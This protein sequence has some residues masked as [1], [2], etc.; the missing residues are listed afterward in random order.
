LRAR[1]YLGEGYLQ[2]GDVAKAKEQLTEIAERCT[3]SC[4]AYGKL[5][6]AIV[7]YLTEGGSADW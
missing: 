4:E 6:Q 1:E 5:E 3:G 7:S 2:K